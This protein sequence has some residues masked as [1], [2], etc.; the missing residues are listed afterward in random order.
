MR[1]FGEYVRLAESKHAFAVFDSCFSGTVFDGA[2]AL[3][4]AA[5]TRATTLPV[6]QFSLCWAI[7][8]ASPLLR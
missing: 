6:R 5:V 8:L 1:R 7:S 2:R 4:P 3:P